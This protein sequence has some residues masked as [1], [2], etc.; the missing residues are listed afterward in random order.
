M[1]RLRRS[2]VWRWRTLC[3][4]NC[5]STLTA[6]P[7]M[8]AQSDAPTIITPLATIYLGDIKANQ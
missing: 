4:S 7:M 6:L 2:I 3:T 1:K 5:E 8:Y